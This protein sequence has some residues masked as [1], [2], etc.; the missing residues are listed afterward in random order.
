MAACKHHFLPPA[1]YCH[2][3]SIS[4][5]ILTLY[6]VHDDGTAP[7]QTPG[8]SELFAIAVQNAANT[9][10]QSA[11]SLS[12]VSAA[13]RDKGRPACGKAATLCTWSKPLANQNLGDFFPPTP[14]AL[15][16]SHPRRN[17][18]RPSVHPRKVHGYANHDQ[19]LHDNERGRAAM[20]A[21]VRQTKWPCMFPRTQC[22]FSC[23][24]PPRAGF[25]TRAPFL[26]EQART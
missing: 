20:E 17:M 15:R 24:G 23:C 10:S 21:S 3:I 16:P 5:Q 25:I 2:V 9:G 18:V 19:C 26:P 1:T 12:L 22:I 14:S 6:L 4:W 13:T 8:F 11:T 7:W